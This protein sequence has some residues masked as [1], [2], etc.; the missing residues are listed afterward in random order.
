MSVQIRLLKS[1]IHF[2]NAQIAGF[3]DSRLFDPE[4]SA[5]L[6]A[7]LVPLVQELQEEIIQL[8][9]KEN[10]VADADALTPQKLQENL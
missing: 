4:E 8:Q 9:A 1:K 6:A 3:H 2:L 7:P 10:D 5:R